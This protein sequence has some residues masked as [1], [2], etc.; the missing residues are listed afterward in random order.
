[1]ARLDPNLHQAL[2]AYVAAA[3]K[4]PPPNPLYPQDQPL[5]QHIDNEAWLIGHYLPWLRA[6]NAPTRAPN[7]GG[8]PV[9]PPG[10]RKY[11]T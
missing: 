7:P 8:R 5:A 9:W 11:N 10:S 2:R 4:Q 6:R 3:N 1:M